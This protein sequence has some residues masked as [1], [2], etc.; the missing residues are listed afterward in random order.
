ML[1]VTILGNNSALPMHDR[2]PTSQLVTNGES[3]FL[4]DCGEGTQI[5]MNRFKIRR[6]RIHHIF[7]SHLHGDHYFGLAGLLNSYS[8]TNR[9][10]ALH[11][12]APAP[13]EE[14]L[15]LQFRAAAARLSY[16]IHF[17]ALGDP[18]LLLDDAKLR[19]ES[20]PVHHRIPCW[21]FRFREKEKLRKIDPKL[22]YQAGIPPDFFPRLKEGED[23]LHPDG[24]R[25][26]NA[27]V[28]KPAPKAVSYAYCADT[29]YEEKILPYIQDADL[30]YHEATYLD[31]QREKA[32]ERFHSTA[33]QAATIALK[34][35]ARRLLLGHFSSKYEVLD[36]FREEAE[37]VF[38]GVEVCR[39]G[40]TY[41][42][43]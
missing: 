38:P 16:P 27:D 8:L 43:K 42:V 34:A 1:A 39:E 23:Y 19:V 2:H 32:M 18:A 33:H 9:Q 10:E 21:G 11:L 20:F 14:I 24:R 31:D 40:V 35:C 3:M 36:V 37:K 28:T 17:H 5:Q 41:L 22:A 12:Y 29:M 13:L 7:I 4:V 15:D 26:H 30:V 6:S 25:V